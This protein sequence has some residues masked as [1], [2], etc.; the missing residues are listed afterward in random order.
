MQG[1]IIMYIYIICNSIEIAPSMPS[2]VHTCNTRPSALAHLD[3]SR[4]RTLVFAGGGN[5]CMWQAGLVTE[6]LARGWQ[7]P[8]RLV[9][10]SAG[11][12]VATALIGGKVEQAMQVCRTLY[13]ANP[14]IVDWS[15]V[16]RGRVSFAHQHIFPAWVASYLNEENFGAL[17]QARSRLTVAFTRPSP[18]LGLHVSTLVG[19]LAYLV[20]KHI[21]HSI[22]PR[23]P[24]WLGLRQGYMD[25]QDCSS[26][27]QAQNLISAAAAAP[28]FMKARIV[29][30][31]NALDGGFVDNAPISAA[32]H[33][34]STEEKAGTLV[35]LTRY[36]P[37]WP[38]LFSWKGRNYWQ[39]NQKVPVSTWDCTPK[40]TIEAAFDAGFQDARSQLARLAW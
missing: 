28:P 1:C 21:S 27:V 34:Q 3:L 33:S 13:A 40:T 14:R 5:R 35:L 9:G 31:G 18:W 38:T 7:L 37:Q 11:A 26:L 25:L 15:E 36:Y 24:K 12:G 17:C 6:L 39:P 32:S 16:W 20:D 23:L 30:D 2:V 4:I 29:G 8:A 19:S 22:H 10:T